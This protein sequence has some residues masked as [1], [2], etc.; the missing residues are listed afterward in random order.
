ML[1]LATILLKFLPFHS[2]AIASAYNINPY[3]TKGAQWLRT[4]T[5]ETDCVDLNFGSVLH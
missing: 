3:L 5:L 2:T 4:Q 1:G